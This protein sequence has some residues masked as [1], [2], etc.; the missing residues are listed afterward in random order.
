MIN[1]ED[2]EMKDMMKFD[3]DH[4]LLIVPDVHGRAFWRQPVMEGGY[5]HV[6]FLGDYT[7]PY[8]AEGISRDSSVEMFR[9]IVAFAEEHQDK[10]TLLLGNH[11]MHYVSEVFG[12]EARGSRYSF[13]SRR[14]VAKLYNA[15]RQLFALAF[16]AEYDGV[17]CLLTHAGVTS[18]WLRAHET[19]VGAPTAANIN[20]LM[21]S[22]EGVRALADVGWTRGGWASSG[23]PMWADCSEMEASEPLPGIFQVFGHTQTWPREPVVRQHMACVDCH[24]TFLLSELVELSRKR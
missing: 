22:D 14:P 15:H 17:H 18:E 23:G 16:E 24:R 6:V 12:A 11:D 8:P 13:W 9:E 1:S 19:I 10:V 4:D 3:K 20:A 2:K 7:D 5:A 21:E